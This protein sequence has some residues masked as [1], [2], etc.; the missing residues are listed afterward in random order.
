MRAVIAIGIVVLA[1]CPDPDEPERVVELVGITSAPPAS[2]G[3]I[4]N[5]RVKHDH[6]IELSVGVA[7]AAR[8]W[9]NCATQVP[10]ASAKLTADH[11]EIIGVRPLYRLGRSDGELVL[12]AQRPGLTTLVVETS[13]ATQSYAVNV[14][15]R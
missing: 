4:T 11:P 15:P 10:C 13:C 3:S 9:D 6:A 8:C 2:T 14:I 5:D 12:V 1:G 7:L